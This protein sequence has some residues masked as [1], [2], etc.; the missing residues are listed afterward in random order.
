MSAERIVGLPVANNQLQ[1]RR[2]VN[3]T[4]EPYEIMIAGQVE[5]F[6]PGE[7][8]DPRYMCVKRVLPGVARDMMK[9]GFRFLREMDDDDGFKL[10][11]RGR[12]MEKVHGKGQGFFAA[13]EEMTGAKPKSP[14]AALKKEQR[15]KQLLAQLKRRGYEVTEKD[16]LEVL[17]KLLHESPVPMLRLKTPE[18]RQAMSDMLDAEATTTAPSDES[19]DD[20]QVLKARLRAEIKLAGGEQPG[21]RA[22]IET[23]EAALAEAKAAKA[24]SA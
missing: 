16:S 19:S 1:L 4:D 12:A 21:N 18:E 22:S 7:L 23:L 15:R 10:I 2:I 13:M 14:T 24:Q 17:E 5:I 20:A 3:V 6:E 8:H 9:H 11:E